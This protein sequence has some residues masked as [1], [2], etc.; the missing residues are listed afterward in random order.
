[1]CEHVSPLR[2]ANPVN[3]SR[4]ISTSDATTAAPADIAVGH[5]PAEAVPAPEH[6]STQARPANDDRES[7]AAD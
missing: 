3:G 2:T 7:D 1:M 4:D 6:E 5:R